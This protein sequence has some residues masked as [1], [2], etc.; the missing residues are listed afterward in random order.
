MISHTSVQ[1]QN[2]QKIIAMF[3]DKPDTVERLEG[4]WKGEGFRTEYFG[5]RLELESLIDRL[6]GKIPTPIE[7]V[8]TFDVKF[9]E[10]F[11]FYAGTENYGIKDPRVAGIEIVEFLTGRFEVLRDTKF[12]L[13]SSAEAEYEVQSRIERLREG[14]VSV[15]FVSKN[16]SEDSVLEK[17]YDLLDDGKKL[18]VFGHLKVFDS[19]CDLIEID[20]RER[21]RVLGAEDVPELYYTKH[22][23]NYVEVSRNAKSRIS[24]F[25]SIEMILRD[26]FPPDEIAAATRTTIL[27]SG[28][29]IRDALLSGSER[30]QEAARRYLEHSIGAHG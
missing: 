2:A 13:M 26:M 7:L 9:D 25:L 28:M 15:E 21:C 23:R 27:P 16:E 29:S 3:D 14:G 5:N 22:I 19:F 11:Q 6:I 8:P 1:A 20:R 12:I 10:P 17:T 30:E 24:T 4:I 18:A